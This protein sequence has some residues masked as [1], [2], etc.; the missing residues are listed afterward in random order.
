MENQTT[1]SATFDELIIDVSHLSS[2]A[3]KSPALSRLRYR[4]AYAM[5]R[6]QSAQQDAPVGTFSHLAE[7][8]LLPPV[9]ELPVQV[10]SEQ[11]P[12]AQRM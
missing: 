1:S 6:N 10:Q 3:P 11:A 8:P 12:D 2:S 7:E 9:T 5:S 4:P